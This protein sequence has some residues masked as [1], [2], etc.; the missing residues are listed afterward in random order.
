MIL[1][2]EFLVWVVISNLIAFPVAWYAMHIWLE[3]FAYRVEIG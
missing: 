3:G 1:S 2:R